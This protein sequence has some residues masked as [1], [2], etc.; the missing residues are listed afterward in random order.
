MAAPDSAQGRYAGYERP[1]V[2]ILF[3]TACFLQSFFLFGLYKFRQM[4][5]PTRELRRTETSS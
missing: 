5:N 1:V 3:I 2:N 4:K